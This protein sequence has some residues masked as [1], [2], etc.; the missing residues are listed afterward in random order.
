[1]NKFIVIATIALCMFLS[2]AISAQVLKNG[3]FE[4]GIAEDGFNQWGFRTVS[5]DTDISFWSIDAYSVD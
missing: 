3:S 5:N 4:Q 1:M 2:T